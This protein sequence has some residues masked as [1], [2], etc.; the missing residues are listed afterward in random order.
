MKKVA[1]AFFLVVTAASAAPCCSRGFVASGHCVDVSAD[2]CARIGGGT[3]AGDACGPDEDGNGVADVCDATCGD[4]TVDPWEDCDGN[5]PDCDENCA[6]PVG[7]CCVYGGAS[8]PTCVTPSPAGE[9]VP[10]FEIPR[11]YR[12]GGDCEDPCPAEPPAS[13]ICLVGSECCQCELN[14]LWIGLLALGFGLLVGLTCAAGCILIA[15]AR[16]EEEKKEK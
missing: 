11:F 9:C 12:P 7:A 6:F 13:A 5:H 1:L 14:Y 15:R 4:D 3:V 2:L 10:T 8:G 16:D